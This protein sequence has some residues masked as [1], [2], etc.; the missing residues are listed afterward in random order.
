[1]TMN[2]RKRIPLTTICVGC[3]ILFVISHKLACEPYILDPNFGTHSL[4]G[5]THSDRT[6]IFAVYF[7]KQGNDFSYASGDYK[8][9]DRTLHL[10][11]KDKTTVEWTFNLSKYLSTLRRVGGELEEAALLLSQWNPLSPNRARIKMYINDFLFADLRLKVKL[12]GNYTWKVPTT[13]NIPGS[14]WA[15]PQLF[16]IVS[17]PLDVIT[18]N[19]CMNEPTHFRIVLDNAVYWDIDYVAVKLFSDYR[20]LDSPWWRQNLGWLTPIYLSATAMLLIMILVKYGP[21]LKRIVFAYIPKITPKRVYLMSLFAISLRLTLAPFMRSGDLEKYHQVS[22][23][24]FFYGLDTRTFLSLY[25][26]V[27][28][29]VLS[30]CYPLYLLPS[31]LAESVYIE[32]LVLK[33]PLIISDIMI[34]FLLYRIGRRFVNRKR[35]IIIGLSWLLNPYAIYMS[36]I[37]GIHHVLPTM[38]ILLALERLVYGHVKSSALALSAG[39]F[40]GLYPIFVLPCFMIAFLRSHEKMKG[41]QFVNFFF[42]GSSLLAFPWPF[43]I[44]IPLNISFGAGRV[45]FASLSYTYLMIPPWL[46]GYWSLALLSVGFAFLC[47]HIYRKSRTQRGPLQMN[48]YILLSFL[49]FY[50]AN[51]IV[52][53]TYVLWSLPFLIIAYTCTRKLPLGYVA[54]FM[55]LPLLWFSYWTPIGWLFRGGE[56]FRDTLGLNFSILALLMIVRLLFNANEPKDNTWKLLKRLTLDKATQIIL[57][58]SCTL[59]VF[60]PWFQPSSWTSLWYNMLLPVFFALSAGLALLAIARRMK[61]LV[62]R[63]R[64]RD[65]FPFARTRKKA[66]LVAAGLLTIMLL[67]NVTGLVLDRFFFAGDSSLFPQSPDAV[68]FSAIVVMWLLLAFHDLLTTPQSISMITWIAVLQMDYLITRHYITYKILNIATFALDL[69]ILTSILIL[70]F[71]MDLYRSKANATRRVAV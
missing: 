38:L 8:S 67:Y 52:F 66:Q 39:V 16:S 7:V 59:I 57:T 41:L 69:V 58:I 62:H 60:A 6:Q 10:E 37:W 26:P 36:S 48:Q 24:T 19:Q 49:I 50:L 20:T 29:A 12:L 43:S 33:L 11:G 46:A 3:V 5:F 34:S 35:A 1:M 54:L 51:T 32:N 42:L 64:L 45:G 40:S 47:V 56:I 13:M 53:P 25:G 68:Y 30:M 65:L 61:K 55:A 2:L 15:Y 9:T 28:H 31:L 63:G 14:N 21:F 27:W 4:H 71:L 70:L 44:A 22:V 17:I 18:R 23:I